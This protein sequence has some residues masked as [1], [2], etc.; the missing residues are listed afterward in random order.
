MLNFK[1]TDSFTGGETP[2]RWNYYCAEELSECLSISLNRSQSLRTVLAWQAMIIFIL[3]MAFRQRL[4]VANWACS[5]WQ[6]WK[7]L[8]AEKKSH[9]GTAQAQHLRPPG[10]ASFLHQNSPLQNNAACVKRCAAP[11]GFWDRF[12]EAASQLLASSQFPEFLPPLPKREENSGG[13]LGRQ[14]VRITANPLPGLR[15]LSAIAGSSKMK[16]L[17]GSFFPAV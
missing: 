7:Q 14:Q 8:R 1:H 16:G 3:G 12:P 6:G 13:K 5:G 17:A 2:K 10:S 4:P 15:I 9:P 11:R